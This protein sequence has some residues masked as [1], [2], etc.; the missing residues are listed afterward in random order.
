M[1]SRS[2]RAG[3]R[4]SWWIGFC[5]SRGRPRCVRPLSIP[6]QVRKL[7][8][9]ANH[10]GLLGAALVLALA[11][12]PVQGVGPVTQPPQPSTGPGGSQP[13]NRGVRV[14]AGGGGNQAWFVFEPTR[15]RPDAAPLAVVIH[16]YYE[17]SG[18]EQM[19][20]L[21]RHTVR[22]GSVVIY[23][24]WQTNVASPCPGPYNIEPC[25]T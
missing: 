7:R 3:R 17:F 12:A 24:R 15:P 23:P 18:Y 14:H 10:L 8:R 2:S 11:A 16:G 13:S 1:L 6:D 22:G 25:M 4:S 20:A 19:E 5:P 9:A 21:I